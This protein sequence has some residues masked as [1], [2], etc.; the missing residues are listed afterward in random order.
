MSILQSAARFIAIADVG[1]VVPIERD[2]SLRSGN[3]VRVDSLVSPSGAI[4]PGVLEG[5]I[6]PVP[7][8][9]VRS[10]ILVQG[11]RGVLPHIAERVNDLVRPADSIPARVLEVFIAHVHV[12]Y[13]GVACAVN[14][15]RSVDADISEPVS[16][17]DEH[18][19]RL[20][21]IAYK[22]QANRQKSKTERADSEYRLEPPSI[23]QV[24]PCLLGDRHLRELLIKTSV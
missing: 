15:Y 16:L 18:V 24:P 14:R 11:H 19:S 7:V 13:M 2:R 21:A 4:P 20:R 17:L 12:A 3:S 22:I 6:G 9:E 8:A 23:S 5:P 1:V 10:V